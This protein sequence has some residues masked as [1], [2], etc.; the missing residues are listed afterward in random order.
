MDGARQ[1][2]LFVK[3][4]F[5]SLGAL[6]SAA[7]GAFFYI[8]DKTNRLIGLFMTHVD[9]ALYTVDEKHL[10]IQKFMKE[11]DSQIE[12]GDRSSTGEDSI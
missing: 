5:L 2:W 4:I 8:K 3:N 10:I 6:I 12:S 11:L 1:F 7:E 9:D